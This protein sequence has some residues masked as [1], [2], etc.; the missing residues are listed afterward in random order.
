VASLINTNCNNTTVWP[1]PIFDVGVA[2]ETKFA[3]RFPA[4]QPIVGIDPVI[5]AGIKRNL[6]H[7]MQANRHA[8]WEALPTWNATHVLQADRLQDVSEELEREAEEAMMEE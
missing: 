5:K 1:Y 6:V 8:F 2:P 3:G 7:L 4:V